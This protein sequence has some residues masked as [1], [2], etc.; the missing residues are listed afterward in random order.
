MYVSSVISNLENSSRFHIEPNYYSDTKI[1][2]ISTKEL[3]DSNFPEKK[4]YNK[5]KSS[6]N[7]SYEDEMKTA[8]HSFSLDQFEIIQTIGK[9]AYSTVYLVKQKTTGKPYALK[10]VRKNLVYNEDNR[11]EHAMAEIK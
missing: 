5:F 2:N 9:G 8:F 6:N 10:S 4:S 3:Q 11:I 1:R 7:V